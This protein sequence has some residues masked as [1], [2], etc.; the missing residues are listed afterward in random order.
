MLYSTLHVQSTT[1]IPLQEHISSQTDQSV[2]MEVVQDSLYCKL[3][4]IRRCIK[5]RAS[6]LLDQTE[7]YSY[8]IN[9]Y[10]IPHFISKYVAWLQISLRQSDKTSNLKKIQLSLRKQEHRMYTASATGGAGTSHKCRGGAA[11][12]RQ[13]TSWGLKGME[14][15]Q[16]EKNLQL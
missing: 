8:F 14:F 11:A 5:T 12:P 3:G 15:I 4:L 7:R 1:S 10:K 9:R 2:M 6:K 16:W 13:V